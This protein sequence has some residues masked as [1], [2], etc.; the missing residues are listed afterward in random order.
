MEA[1]DRLLF[2][3]NELQDLYGNNLL[4]SRFNLEISKKVR[5]YLD[6]TEEKD[7]LIRCNSDNIIKC[8]KVFTKRKYTLNEILSLYKLLEF[9]IETNLKG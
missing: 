4:V 8:T 3:L 6:L 7:N 9:H 1:L 2:R 5:E